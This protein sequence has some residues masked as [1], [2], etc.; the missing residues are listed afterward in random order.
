MANEIEITFKNGRRTFFPSKFTTEA[1]VE[2]EDQ[3]N[4]EIDTINGEVID[5]PSNGTPMAK[6]GT[7]TDTSFNDWLKEN[8]ITVYKRTYYWVADDGKGDYRQVANTKS[9]VMKAL[10]DEWEN[11]SS[12]IDIGADNIAKH[13]LKTPNQQYASKIMPGKEVAKRMRNYVM[14]KGFADRVEKMPTITGQQ[15]EEMLPDYI[16][17]WEIRKAFLGD[18]EKY[19][20]KKWAVHYIDVYKKKQR[21]V[22]ELGRMSDKTDVNNAL[23]RR[24]DVYEVLS[25]TEVAQ[26]G[27]KTNLSRENAEMVLNNNKQIKHHTNEIENVITADTHVPAW[28]VAK[29]NRSASDL[30]DATHYL[31]GAKGKEYKGGGVIFNEIKNEKEK[32]TSELFKKC[33]VFFAFSDKQFHENKTPLKPGEKYVSIGVGGYLPKGKLDAFLDGMEA[34][35]KFGKTKVKENNLAETEILYEL[36]NH[37][38]FYTGEIDD[39][40]NMFKGT[41]TDKQIRDV[42]NKHRKANQD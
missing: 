40:V 21:I 26:N 39:V 13:G 18:V 38:C 17:G 22:L 28:V 7:K 11:A 14:L 15:L 37:E 9:D 25:I 16:P 3:F 29:V 10:H 20:S 2:L 41:Y 32:M 31:D 5:K 33:G 8:N 4:S 35:N 19:P 42:Y 12:K 34:I 23:K 30:S 1:L 27:T 6:R 24:G 36:K